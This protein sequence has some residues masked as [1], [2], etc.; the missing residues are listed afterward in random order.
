MTNQPLNAVTR[1]GQ[2]VWELRTTIKKLN[3]AAESALAHATYDV[4]LLALHEERIASLQDQMDELVV[5][6]LPEDQRADF[7][8]SVRRIKITGA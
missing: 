2:L 8:R 4:D 6:L 5:S 1:I 3:R 7:W